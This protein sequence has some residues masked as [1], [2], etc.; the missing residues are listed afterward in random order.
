MRLAVPTVF[1]YRESTVLEAPSTP[2]P[3]HTFSLFFLLF[4]SSKLKMPRC[5]L[6]V[7][8]FL[9]SFCP[10]LSLRSWPHLF[11]AIRGPRPSADGPGH[12]R[13]AWDP[14]KAW[15]KSTNQKTIYAIKYLNTYCTKKCDKRKRWRVMRRF[16][17][18]SPIFNMMK[19]H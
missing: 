13:M 6:A 15:P 18:N 4:F 12:T 2:R 9:G 16:S 10:L 5:L 7:R 17:S 19:S 8:R 11:G 14:S 1:V 3:N